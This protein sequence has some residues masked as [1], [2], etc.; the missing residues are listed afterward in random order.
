[1]TRRNYTRYANFTAESYE[2]KGVSYYL[3]RRP[4]D[5]V[6]VPVIQH[7]QKKRVLEVGLGTGHYTTYFLRQACEVTG[8]D[9]NPHL[10]RHLDIPIIQATADNFG[11]SLQGDTF[12]VVAS[13]WMTEYLTPR[14][15]Q[16]F[17]AQALCCLRTSGIF[18][19]TFVANQQW[20]KFYQTGS[21]LRGIKKFTYGKQDIDNFFPNMPIKVIHLPG[22][23]GGLL[24]YLVSLQSF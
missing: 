4:A 8:V 19:T 15:V 1:M 22:L 9:I 23:W 5:S 17:I 18:I 2:R 10:G 24:G 13:F 12:D 14:E 20:G 6:L 16:A 11:E 3:Y 21:W 7:I